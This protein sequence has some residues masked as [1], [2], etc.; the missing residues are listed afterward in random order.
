MESG[1]IK[2]GK[3]WKSGLMA[4][5]LGGFYGQIAQAAMNPQFYEAQLTV[6]S[7]TDEERRQLLAQGLL[8]VLERVGGQSGVEKTAPVKAA[9]ENPTALVDQY[10]Y[11]GNTMIVKYS[12][13]GVNQ[14]LKQSGQTGWGQK[15]PQVLLWLAIDDQDQRKLIGAD[16]D[17]EV[18]KL[19]KQ[20]GQQKG[21]PLILPLLDIEDLSSI[22]VDDVM[23]QF[24]PVLQQ[25]SK[26]YGGQAILIGRLSH[27]NANWEGSW[28]LV[29]G[30]DNT[31]WQAEG[32]TLDDLL[33]QGMT[34]T[35]H[36]LMNKF[37][38][39]NNTPVANPTGP[40]QRF[41]IQVHNIQSGPDFAKIEFYLENLDQVSKVNL[42]QVSN[43][44]AIFEVIPKSNYGKE[45][46]LAAIGMEKQL[47][48]MPG[49]SETL[50]QNNVNYRWV[51]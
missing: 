3:R 7:Q 49:E 9:L 21:L 10:S 15:R 35:S 46:V 40:S 33:S 39:K 31:S 16:A 20:L 27:K 37:G 12:P 30:T 5:I 45:A 36:Y 41:L 22:S 13:E 48:S 26:R 24:S 29:T 25:A 14:L 28:E 18:L 11:L 44:G 23:G 4:A 43:T 47:V 17:P 8:Q 32:K 6:Q 34:G 51:P 38:I 42:F 1:A 50:S 2:R 19:V